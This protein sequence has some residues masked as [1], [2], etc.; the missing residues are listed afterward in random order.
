MA[1][2]VEGVSR[3]EE[4]AAAALCS[5]VVHLGVDSRSTAFRLERCAFNDATFRVPDERGCC[6]SAE[7]LLSCLPFGARLDAKLPLDVL[8]AALRAEGHEC[9]AGSDPGRFV[10]NCLYALSLHQAAHHPGRRFA[11]FVHVPPFSCISRET[12]LSFVCAL[13]SLLAHHLSSQGLAVSYT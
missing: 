8:A 3:L 12:Q 11:L 1:A 9:E 13:L 10:C 6:P 7:R 2:A 4:E 5:C